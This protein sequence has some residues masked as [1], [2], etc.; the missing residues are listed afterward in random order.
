MSALR[1]QEVWSKSET[2]TRYAST[3]SVQVVH[4][5]VSTPLHNEDGGQRW[6][7]YAI[8]SDRHPRF[9]LIEGYDIW[10]EALQELPL[11]W[12]CTFIQKSTMSFGQHVKVGSD[13]AHVDDEE[14]MRA[15]EANTVA[16]RQ[17]FADAQELYDF[18]LKEEQAE[19]CQEKSPGSFLREEPSNDTPTLP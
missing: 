6:N 3:F 4:W 8:I 13:Y 16:A 1:R 7:V 14:Y 12:G 18:L 15:T 10:Q 19:S 11:Y 17:V 5:E 2:W 9:K